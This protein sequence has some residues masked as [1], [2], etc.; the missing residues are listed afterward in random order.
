LEQSVEKGG[1]SACPFTTSV[2][3]VFLF[4][5]GE[6]SSLMQGGERYT[7]QAEVKQ[8]NYSEGPMSMT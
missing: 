8:T 6:R 7:L 5:E 4:L 1:L 3:P 2:T